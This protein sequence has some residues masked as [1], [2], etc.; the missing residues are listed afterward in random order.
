M[1]DLLDQDGRTECHQCGQSVPT[2]EFASH[3]EHCMGHGNDNPAEPIKGTGR[4]APSAGG[5]F[6]ARG[7]KRRERWTQDEGGEFVKTDKRKRRK[8]DFDPTPDEPTL[9]LIAYEYGSLI[10]GQIWEAAAGDG[11]MADILIE[12]GL[13]VFCSDLVD[14]GRDYEIRDFF[15]YRKPPN[16]IR[17]LVTNPPFKECT[18]RQ[19]KGR[20]IVHA[21][22]DLQLDYM[23]LLLPST[24]PFAATLDPVWS[25]FPPSRI[26]AM[27]WKIDFS[28]EGNPSENHCWYIWDRGAEPGSIDFRVM[29]KKDPR[30]WKLI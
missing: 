13:D 28:G 10:D 14:R 6:A 27:R 17:K 21:W 24:W 22:R 29:D 20:W 4:D 26:Y 1:S 9:S 7:R 15:D 12:C 30:Q 19:G 18:A 11:A 3:L 5:A 16:G 25:K 2:A 8:D 23:A